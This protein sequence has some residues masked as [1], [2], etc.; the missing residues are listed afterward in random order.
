MKKA[1]D[2]PDHEPEERVREGRGEGELQRQLPHR[3]GEVPRRWRAQDVWQGYQRDPG[4][5]RSIAFAE[6]DEPQ[7]A[8]REKCR[9]DPPERAV[10]QRGAV[11]AGQLGRHPERRRHEEHHVTREAPSEASPAAAMA[12]QREA[13]GQ[14]E[15]EARREHDVR[16][17]GGCQAR[18]GFRCG[19]LGCI[20]MFRVRLLEPLS[21][22]NERRHLQ[23]LDGGER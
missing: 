5:S 11:Q 21:R 8:C 12:P 15:R 1:H 7:A 10:L 17:R 19:G 4:D 2:G 9:L 23:L 3:A 20:G 6:R 22:F 18:S 16:D 14:N 13:C